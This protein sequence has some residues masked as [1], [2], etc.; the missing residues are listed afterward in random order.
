MFYF[1]LIL[2]IMSTENLKSNQFQDAMNGSEISNYIEKSLNNFS[3]TKNNNEGY[4]RLHNKDNPNDD[5]DQLK[6]VSGICFTFVALFIL[7][8]YSCLL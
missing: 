5:G 2:K 4:W 1:T 7:G 6:A 8:T 3:S